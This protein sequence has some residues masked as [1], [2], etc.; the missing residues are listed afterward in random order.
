MP[1][2]LNDMLAIL[3]ALNLEIRQQMELTEARA[4]TANQLVAQLAATGLMNDRIFLGDVILTRAYSAHYETGT[5]Q[6]IQAG[7]S[8]NGG[9]GAVCWDSEEF[10]TLEEVG[11]LESEAIL[12]HVPF[13]RCDPAIKAR[14]LPQLE[15]LL[16]ALCRALGMD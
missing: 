6:V 15:A 10:A 5:G 16:D 9:F 3:R 12:K 8:V 7:L 1:K 13:E 11:E 14:L 4:E 2:N